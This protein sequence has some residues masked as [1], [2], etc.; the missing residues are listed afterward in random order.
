MEKIK[1][2]VVF[3]CFALFWVPVCSFA[4]PSGSS[5]TKKEGRL[6]EIDSVNRYIFV[7]GKKYF[8]SDQAKIFG[9]SG[10]NM[11]LQ[12]LRKNTDVRFEIVPSKKKGNVSV[13]NLIRVL[14]K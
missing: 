3:A 8:V 11:T 10:K 9:P 7:S 4:Q 14:I 5:N 6:G 12:N 2:F 13:V 1:R